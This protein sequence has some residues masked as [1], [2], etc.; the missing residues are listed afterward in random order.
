M[1][2][3]RRSLKGQCHEMDIFFEGLNILFVLSVYALIVSRSFQ[4]LSLSYT[5]IDF[6]FASLKL[7]IILKMLTE[8]RLRIRASSLVPTSQTKNCKNY[9]RMYRKYIS[10]I[11]SLQ[12]NYLSRDNPFK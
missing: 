7:L 3:Y 6:L 4:S 10:I 8:T 2:P 5:I 11:I 9:Q 1:Y 12:Q